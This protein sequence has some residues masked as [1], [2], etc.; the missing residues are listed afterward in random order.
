MK[1]FEYGIEKTFQIT[2]HT[3]YISWLMENIFNTITKGNVPLWCR[4]LCLQI[5]RWNKE[6]TCTRPIS[7]P[8]I[9]YAFFLGILV[10]IYKLSSDLGQWILKFYLSLIYPTLSPSGEYFWW[11]FCLLAKTR[12]CFDKSFVHRVNIFGVLFTRKNKKLFW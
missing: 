6:L 8:R 12:N 5:H 10:R 2:I 1:M 7:D 3:P 9:P 11:Q 4:E